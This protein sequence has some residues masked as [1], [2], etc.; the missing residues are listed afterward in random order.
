MRKRERGRGRNEAQGGAGIWGKTTRAKMLESGSVR[1][2]KS[3]V[4]DIQGG[5]LLSDDILVFLRL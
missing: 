4:R 3:T 5:A 2:E 1:S